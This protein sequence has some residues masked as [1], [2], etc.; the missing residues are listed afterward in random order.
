[1]TPFFLFFFL[2]FLSFFLSFFEGFAEVALGEEKTT[3]IIAAITTTTTTTANYT[4]LPQFP[5]FLDEPTEVGDSDVE[6]VVVLRFPSR[7]IIAQLT[8]FHQIPVG[9]E[10]T[11]F[12]EEKRGESR[13]KRRKAMR[14]S[15]R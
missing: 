7:L 9:K 14:K 6:L 12:A 11:G 4:N 15:R 2:L 13:K 8:P 1:M 3:S 5:I 10:M